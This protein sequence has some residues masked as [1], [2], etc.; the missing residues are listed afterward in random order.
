MTSVP[1][2]DWDLAERVGALL[3]DPGPELG[4][5]ELTQ[6]VAGLR[7]AAQRAEEIVARTTG[8][9][10]PP[11]APP[12]VVDRPTWLRWNV[13]LA[14][15]IFAPYVSERASLP[16]RLAGE[17]TAVQVGTVLAWVSARV[18]GQYDPYA[19]V[20]RL[21][22]VAPTVAAVER[23]LGVDHDAF[24]LWICIH[25]V[26][27]RY[28]FGQAPWLAEHLRGLVAQVVD[29][30]TPSL[31]GLLR[32]GRSLSFAE[33]ALGPQG[34]EALASVT[35]VMSL[36][37]GYAD[38]MMD[39]TD[40][41]PGVASLRAKLQGRRTAPGLDAVMRGLMG[42]DVKHA[43]YSDGAAFCTAVIDRVG[44]AGLNR[45]YERAENLPSPAEIADPGS[46]VDRVC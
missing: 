9:T 3:V 1:P 40:E 23:S 29:A 46:W 10:A 24:R 45:V 12:L 41:V 14:S 36:V 2:V 22:L 21:L 7:V 11:G 18:L 37:E 43:Q 28:Q 30:E 38:V 44:V 31:L 35:A 33:V 34:R 25:E 4:E 42:L 8:L 13:R 39:R 32:G 16:E 26:T 15:W 5:P 27:H 6:V 17:A 19:E 20:P